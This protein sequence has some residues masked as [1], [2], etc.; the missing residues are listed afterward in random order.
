MIAVFLAAALQAAPG[1]VP[2]PPPRVERRREPSLAAYRAALD[3]LY[4]GRPEAALERL[5]GLA[6]DQPGD[7]LG[8]YLQALVLCWRLEQRPESAALDREFEQRASRA[9]AL[10]D[11][12]LKQD[13]ADLRSRL[14]RGAVHG[15]KSRFHMFRGHRGDA[16]REA[17]H[18]RE[19]L[20]AIHEQDPGDREALFGLGLY[21]YYGD[22]LPRVAKVLRFLAR[23]PGGDGE[24][25]LLRIE[26]AADGA[27]LHEVE[28]RAQ[29]YEIYAFY[30]DRPDRALE[31]VRGLH[32]RYPHWPLWG[33]KLAEHLRDR[34]GNYRES[35]SV[36]AE[37]VE[38][39]RAREIGAG[40]AALARLSLG[41]SLLLDL[42]PAEARRVL[43]PVKDLRPELPALAGQARLLLGR[44]LEIEGDRDGAFAHYRAAAESPDR[45]VRRRAAEALDR[46]LPPA[47]VRAL[48]FLGE[49]RRARE[50]GRHADAATAYAAALEVSPTSPEA[51]LG[52]AEAAL[53]DGEGARARELLDR[54]EDKKA[55]SPPTL[56]A[57]AALLRGEALQASGRREA[58]VQLYKKVLQDPCA[59]A[60]TRDRAATLLRAADPRP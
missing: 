38:P 40:A 20:L 47:H 10:A 57:W 30:E 51:L 22:V 15:V 28:V 6:G 53:H 11:E 44:G 34:M 17:V 26:Q 5:D 25:G 18:M 31:E 36:A 56:R 33:L 60:E 16:A 48:H 43:L 14:A 54:V 24:R 12:R 45:D 19:D 29:L 41:E 55:T 49:A 32:R 42:R 37:M 46:P 58:A 59:A 39:R 50:L 35:A 3:L 23:M 52:A 1:G 9:L 21:D 27:V 7:P 2:S 4:D 8:V 13:P